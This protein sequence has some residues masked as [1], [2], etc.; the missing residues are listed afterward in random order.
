ME[1]YPEK[2]VWVWS[3]YTFEDYLKKQDA[4]KYI[5]IIVDGQYVDNLHDPRLKW[6]GS[7]NQRVIDV[8]KSLKNDKVELFC[9]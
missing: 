6:R 1:K 2:T 7:S 8:Q 5:D 3:G 4:I 9:D